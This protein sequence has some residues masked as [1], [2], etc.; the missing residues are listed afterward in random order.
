MAQLVPGITLQHR[1]VLERSL[2]QGAAAHTFLAN[3]LLRNR[4]VALK[5]LHAQ[6]HDLGAILEREFLTLCGLSHPHLSRVHDYGVGWIEH[7]PFP[8]YTADVVP[9]VHLADFARD[10][11]WRA[12]LCPLGHVLSALG[13]LHEL[14]V[15]HGDIKSENVLVRD[16]GFGVLIDLSCAESFTE[17]RP[18][19]F[20]TPANWAPEIRMGR[21]ADGRADIYS[22]GRMLHELV[23]LVRGEVPDD[24]RRLL[25]SLTRPN[26]AERPA[27]VWEVAE[28]LGAEDV[29]RWLPT[30]DAPRFVGRHSLLH[31]FEA[32]IAALLDRRS[33]PRVLCAQGADGMGKSRLLREL[34]WRSQVQCEVVTGHA[35][36]PVAVASLLSRACT[37]EHDGVPFD[38]WQELRK[39]GPIVLVLDD[40]HKLSEPEQWLLA[41]CLRTTEPTDGVLWILSSDGSAELPRAEVLALEPLSSE[42]LDA[43]TGAQLSAPEL[44]RLSQLSGRCPA[45]VRALSADMIAGRLVAEDQTEAIFDSR[46][47][48]RLGG[49]SE[50][51]LRALAVVATLRSSVDEA[52]LGALEIPTEALAALERSLWVEQEADGWRLARVVEG[53]AIIRAMHADVLTRVRVAVRRELERRISSLEPQSPAGDGRA[54]TDL[55][56]PLQSQTASRWVEQLFDTGDRKAAEAALL[57]QRPDDRPAAW[58]RVLAKVASVTASNEVR[59]LHARVVRLTDGPP[60]AL[61]LLAKLIRSR[62]ARRWAHLAWCEAAEACLRMA[63]FERVERQLSRARAL[64]SKAD[65]RARVAEIRARLLV[66]RGAYEEAQAL[67]RDALAHVVDQRLRASLEETAGLTSSYLGK[68]E[69]ADAHLGNASAL[70]TRVGTPEAIAKLRCYQA[71]H[72]YRG[73]RLD[74]SARW[75]EEALSLA[76]HHGARDLIASTALNLATVHHQAGAWGRALLAYE[77]AATLAA[78]MNKP[79]TISTIRWNQ[80][81]LYA[82]VGALERAERLLAG[83]TDD[84]SSS[85]VE[86][87]R[88]VTASLR[89]EIAFARNELASAAQHFAAASA[90]YRALKTERDY[91]EAEL[92]RAEVDL[93]EQR[94]ATARRRVDAVQPTLSSLDAEDLAAR[95]ELIRGRILIEQGSAAEAERIL[96]SSL[97]RAQRCGMVHLQAEVLEQLSAAWQRQG[98]TVLAAEHRDRARAAWER[99]AATLPPALRDAFW[100]HPRRCLQQ[101]APPASAGLSSSTLA[102]PIRRLLAINRRLSSSLNV[103]EVLSATMDAAMELTGAERGFLLLSEAEGQGGGLRVAVAHNLDRERVEGSN[104]DFSRGIAERVLSTGE[105]ILTVDALEDERFRQNESV[106]AMQLRSVVCVPVRTAA[107]RRGALYLDHRFHPGRFRDG[108]LEMLLAFADQV[109]IALHNARL[110]AAVEQQ[111]K[112]LEHKQARIEALLREQADE[113]D[114]LQEQVRTSDRSNRFA[115]RDIIG[116]SPAMQKVFGVLDRVVE[117]TVPVVVWGESGTGKELVARAIHGEG[118]RRRGPFVSVNCA[119]LPDALLESELFGHVRGAFTGAVRERAGLFVAACGGTL[120]LDEIGEMSPSMQVKLLRVLQEREVRP[121]GANASTAIDVRLVCATNRNLR[122]DVAAGRFREDLFYRV[123]VIEVALPPLRDRAQDILPLAEHLLERAATDQ[124]RSVP[125]LTP[126]A[127][128]KL[129]RYSWPGNV[130]QL[131]NV[132]SKALILTASERIGAEALDLPAGMLTPRPVVSRVEHEAN[133]RQRILSALNAH[134][135]NASEAARSL[136][137]PRTT[138]YRKL[139]KHGIAR[140]R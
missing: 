10:R 37:T 137:I 78:A 82:D 130:R 42:D 115:Y 118:P 138:F 134:G 114:R 34:T 63:R 62:P 77:R 5:A 104:A 41:A 11:T 101:G 76:E 99:V 43:W 38:K 103:S 29:P 60:S 40:V 87:L 13:Q 95:S 30:G 85:G 122:Q 20:G 75:Y 12:V 70:R 117:A 98:A 129:V 125:S 110:H 116:A 33:G 56:S 83:V 119:A 69:Q 27:S 124:R 21:S 19:A 72:A 132:L 39:N 55:R 68:T 93:A 57:V 4:S 26:V 44:R 74:E 22:F 45:I 89:G 59:W 9:G 16:D 7:T 135:W 97:G 71:L 121:V 8:F 17:Q 100:S 80:A 81:K 86:E 58:R 25:A 139:S 88:A 53:P 106:H 102:A 50:P 107:D 14:G 128:R 32:A 94:S 90:C 61:P 3:D 64:A 96:V 36:A 133:E 23:P 48:R 126:K 6:Q 111:A 28:A 15:R 123:A 131:D 24:A 79:S 109:G 140:G 54:T 105:P 46:V 113:I 73:G 108:D 1:Y 112:E 120:F 31:R 66:Q 49:L 18:T 47:A 52:W 92:Q 2:G 51:M 65:D 127:L 91:V 84:A 136:G 35:R 67:A